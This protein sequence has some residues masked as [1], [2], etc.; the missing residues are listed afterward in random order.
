MGQAPRMT[1]SV[2]RRG[3]VHGELYGEENFT[4][5]IM[6]IGPLATFIWMGLHDASIS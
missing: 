4:S 2:S 6:L 1:C 5:D 3:E